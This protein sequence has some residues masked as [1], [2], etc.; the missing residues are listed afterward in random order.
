MFLVPVLVRSAD[1]NRRIHINALIRAGLF[2]QE[3]E[4]Y[5]KLPLSIKLRSTAAYTI[6]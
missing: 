1:A 5:E 4:K 2:Q 3:M 6:G